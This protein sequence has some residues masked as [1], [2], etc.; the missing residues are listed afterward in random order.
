MALHAMQI[1]VDKESISLIVVRVCDM[2]TVVLP[3]QWLVNAR[4]HKFIVAVVSCI[5]SNAYYACS[6]HTVYTHT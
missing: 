4:M 5:G 3:A 6:M 2:C 1:S